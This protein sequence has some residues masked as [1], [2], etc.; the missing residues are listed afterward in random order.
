MFV[1]A[2]KRRY[3]A[4]FTKTLELVTVSGLI[5]FDNVLWKGK[6]IK[7]TEKQAMAIYDLNTTI[8][9]NKRV[10]NVL[11]SVNDGVNVIRKLY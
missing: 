2:D 3:S 1:D 5:V 6:V 4:Y 7:H 11:L 9:Q 10:K 8:V